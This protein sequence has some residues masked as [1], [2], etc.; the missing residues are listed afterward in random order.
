MLWLLVHLSG[1]YSRLHPLRVI[2]QVIAIA[3]GV[4]LGYAINLINS[5]AL[6]EFSGAVRHV[7][8]QADFSVSGGRVG[9]DEALYAQIAMLPEVDIA[10]PIIEVEA[11]VPTRPRSAAGLATLKLMGI[12]ALRAAPLSLAFWPCM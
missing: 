6:D 7:M 10:S 3:V 2:V 1:G 12:D 8:G 9:F 4:A 5:A 11:P